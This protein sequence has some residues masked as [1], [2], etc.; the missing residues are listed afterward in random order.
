MDNPIFVG[1]AEN[2]C[3]R[4]AF[5]IVCC[6]NLIDL[7]TMRYSTTSLVT[8]L[9]LAATSAWAAMDTLPDASKLPPA[10]TQAGLTYDKDI[11]PIFNS[12]CLNCHGEKRHSA[13]LRLDT[14]DAVMKGSKDHQVVVPGDS[15]KSRL[16]FA[17]ANIDGK[18][19][20]PPPP[21]KPR[22]PDGATNAPPPPPPPPRRT[23]TTEQV[24]LIRAWVDQGAK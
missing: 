24:A 7:I 12:A 13:G 11:H 21:R 5:P 18:I 6:G 19:Y 14:L 9:A 4:E 17:V 8:L 15:T 10:S 20:M 23:L 1:R 22:N 2:S 16:V 3:N